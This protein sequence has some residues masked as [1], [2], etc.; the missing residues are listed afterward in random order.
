[1]INNVQKFQSKLCFLFR[2]SNLYRTLY[3]TKKN[4]VFDKI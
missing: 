2:I 1:M 4:V 3:E